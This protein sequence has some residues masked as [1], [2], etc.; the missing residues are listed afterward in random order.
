MIEFLLNNSPV[1]ISEL[2][3][4]TTVLDY[5]REERS[6][7]GTKEGC[8]SGDCGACTVVVAEPRDGKLQYKNCNS[9]ITFL[10]SLHGKQLV[11]VEHLG[12]STGL[13]PVQSA[14]V[15]HHGSQCGFCTPGFIMSLFSLYKHR[16]LSKS[17]RSGRKVIDEFL[18]G[19]LCR[20]TGYKPIIHAAKLSMKY[21]PRDGFSANEKEIVRSLNRIIRKGQSGNASFHRPRS[22]KQLVQLM[23]EI[24]TARLVVGGTDLALEVTQQLKNIDPIIYL[25]NV[26]E[27]NRISVSKTHFEFG[28]SVS[29]NDVKDI[30]KKDYPDLEQLLLRFGS[31]QVRNTGSIGGNI[32]NASPIGDLPPVLLALGAVLTLQSESGKRQLS[33]KNF[34]I[35]Y[36]VT[37]LNPGEFLRSIRIPRLK[38]N[39][40]LKIYKISKRIDDDISAVC[41]AF[42]IQLVKY[43]IREI[44]IGFGG[45]AA[46]PKTASH[47]EQALVNQILEEESVNR[48][49]EALEKDF[50]PIDDVRA[51]AAY[52]MKIA[53]NLIRRLHIELTRPDIKTRI[54]IHEPP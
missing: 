11:T 23:Q 7:C 20:C 34:F 9:C 5:L 19:N 29:L 36:R 43:R 48:A 14:M 17:R 22:C 13:H 47:C 18:G 3:A 51:S 32:A 33:A 35:D 42:S 49:M 53:K 40:Q 25:G 1:R 45:M 31:R 37:A 6:L 26:R 24:P 46:I 4:D 41:A 38:R 8:A 50:S 30:V 39:T 10:G 54:D 52:R 16:D 12:N 44:S 28:A 21:S 27:L 15:E 2:K